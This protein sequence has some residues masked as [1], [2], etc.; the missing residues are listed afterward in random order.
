MHRIM[1]LLLNV[2]YVNSCFVL[3]W[4]CSG[5]C[6]VCC[7]E[8]SSKFSLLL[9]LLFHL[10]FHIFAFF[11]FLPILFF[12][13][14]FPLHSSLICSSCLKKI[15]IVCEFCHF[16]FIFSFRV[17]PENHTILFTMFLCMCSE[18]LHLGTS[19][20]YSQT[21]LQKKKNTQGSL[22]YTIN[23]LR[24]VLYTSVV[25]KLSGSIIFCGPEGQLIH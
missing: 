5:I 21:I 12:F 18:F 22:S 16:S 9:T 24:Y 17:T 14:G 2:S 7:H 13:S 15:S 6:N 11:F 19:Q 20:V 8:S 23:F 4:N 10:S 25:D 3:F 1:P